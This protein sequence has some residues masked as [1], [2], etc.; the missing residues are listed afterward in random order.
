MGSRR[1]NRLRRRKRILAY[2]SCRIRPGVPQ[3][4]AGAGAERTERGGDGRGSRR[5]PVDRHLRIG[6]DES[7]AQRLRHVCRGG[8]AALRGFAAGDA[9]GRVLRHLAREIRDYAEALRRQAVRTDP[10]GVAEVSH[11]FWVGAFHQLDGAAADAEAECEHYAG[12][13]RTAPERTGTWSSSIRQC[14]TS[15]IRAM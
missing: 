4:H 15:A 7:C 13:L 8:R 10:P 6:R 1:R 11:L 2:Q 3:L 14:A 12:L 5:Q 9:A